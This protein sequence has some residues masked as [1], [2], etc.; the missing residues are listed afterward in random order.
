MFTHTNQ[1]VLCVENINFSL[2]LKL[3]FVRFLNDTDTIPDTIRT[4]LFC[5]RTTIEEGCTRRY[6]TVE[7]KL[8][9]RKYDRTN[10]TETF[11]VTAFNVLY[12]VLHLLYTNVVCVCRTIGCLGKQ[13][14]SSL[15]KIICK[16]KFMLYVIIK[17]AII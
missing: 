4:L 12:I 3:L 11:N 8:L 15:S 9:A 17:R 7:W 6:V 5:G 16:V 2:A 13:L 14:L 10:K 1:L